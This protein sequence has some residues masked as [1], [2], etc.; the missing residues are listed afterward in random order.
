MYSQRAS[1][2]FNHG[3]TQE[4]LRAIIFYEWRGDIGATAAAHN[5]ATADWTRAPLP[6]R[7]SSAGSLALQAETP[8]LKKST[9]RDVQK[10]AGSMDPSH[11][12]GWQPAYKGIHM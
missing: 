11:F 9:G 4:Q 1:L 12:Y 3:V 6:L 2:N 7:L 10:S 8:T 5:R